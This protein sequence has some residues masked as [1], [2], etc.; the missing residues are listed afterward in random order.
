[1]TTE[2]DEP[3]HGTSNVS[4]DASLKLDKRDFDEKLCYA[5]VKE[6]SNRK[7]ELCRIPAADSPISPHHMKEE[8]NRKRQ[9]CNPLTQVFVSHIT[10]STLNS[11]R[12]SVRG[13]IQVA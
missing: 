13:D 8:Q 6:N 4:M 3:G 12:T 10:S 1:M 2:C 9:S 5:P 11:M 7:I